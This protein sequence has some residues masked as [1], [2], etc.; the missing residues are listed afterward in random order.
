[1]MKFFFGT[2]CPVIVFAAAASSY[3]HESPTLVSAEEER[4]NA[5]ETEI[6]Y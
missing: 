4:Q 5:A 6:I 2:H 3:E 1:M